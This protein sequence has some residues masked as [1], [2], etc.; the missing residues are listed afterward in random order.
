MGKDIAIVSITLI[1]LVLAIV[2]LL[3]Q[4]TPTNSLKNQVFETHSY[5]TA[6]C[7]ST[8]YCQDYHIKC[9]GKNILNLNPLTGAAIQFDSD[10]NDPR[11]ESETN[12]F[13]N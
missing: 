5:T 6:I 2:A 3:M 9:N 10:W 4:I 7:D 11:N 1:V 12:G 13:C 8:N